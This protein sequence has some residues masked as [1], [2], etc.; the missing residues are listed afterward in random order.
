MARDYARVRMDIWADADF[1]NLSLPAQHL[2][3]LLLT[4]PSLNYCGV[5]DWRPG[6]IAVLS[7]THDAASVI[8]AG[9]ELEAKRYIVVDE[10]TE[11]VLLRSFIRH[12]GL[13]KD[14]RM[15]VALWKAWAGSASSKLR[16]VVVHEMRRLHEE[17]PEM[18][19]WFTTKG[20]TG[21]ARELLRAEVVDPADC[22][23]V[24]G[25]V[26]PSVRGS[27]SPSVRG[28][29]RPNGQPHKGVDLNPITPTPTPS[30]T[31]PP[32]GGG[33]QGGTEKSDVT[34][35]TARSARIDQDPEG[36]EA[37]WAAYPR[38]TAKGAAIKAYRKALDRT[39]VETLLRAV[40]GHAFSD[41][42]KFIPHPATWLNQQRWDDEQPAGE[43]RTRE[44]R[45]RDQG[46]VWW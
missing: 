18:Q 24:L 5:A 17:S 28:S 4:S 19:G 42:P 6:R 37:W 20:A 27:V 45:L 46:G 15:G 40:K 33:V 35:N 32:N 2:Y 39:D 26:A 29:V 30:T 36:F 21:Q 25:D 23:P 31:T 9:A 22:R 34:T 43:T 10:D 13:M 7:G 41:D 38:K 3:L 44:Q 14:A 1:R 16:G 8:E 11:E 12:D